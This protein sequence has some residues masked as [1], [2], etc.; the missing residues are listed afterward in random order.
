LNSQ[1]AQYSQKRIHTLK[2]NPSAILKK[3]MH[4][5]Y[6]NL[7]CQ[8][9]LAYAMPVCQRTAKRTAKPSQAKP[10]QASSK[11][12]GNLASVQPSK[13]AYCVRLPKS[14]CLFIGQIT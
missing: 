7:V 8:N 1:T 11:P 5:N 6:I 4:I 9:H 12:R 3:L 10:S 13:I 2:T 14:H